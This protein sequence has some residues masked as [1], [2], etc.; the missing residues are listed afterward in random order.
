MACQSASF[1][2]AVKN[3]EGFALV[4][5]LFVVAA[6]TILGVTILSI[7]MMNA[8]SAGYMSLNQQNFQIAEAGTEVGRQIIS[9]FADIGGGGYSFGTFTDW[10]SAINPGNV[11]FP[12]YRHMIRPGILIPKTKGESLTFG[13]TYA[14]HRKWWQYY[15]INAES[16]S[17]R[18]YYTLNQ[19]DKEIILSVRKRFEF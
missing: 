16:V 3:E 19:R 5:A 9:G 11:E 1:C 10:S 8:E 6:L 17:G 4:L 15:Q 13:T 18:S 14:P 7:S 12:K 2:K